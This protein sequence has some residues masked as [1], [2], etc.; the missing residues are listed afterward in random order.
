MKK[1]LLNPPNYLP[2]ELIC[3]NFGVL[4]EKSKSLLFNSSSKLKDKI[5]ELNQTIYH[6]SEKGNIKNKIINRLENLINE[7]NRNWK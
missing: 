5:A 2:T 3:N 1:T 6:V 7:N 4:L